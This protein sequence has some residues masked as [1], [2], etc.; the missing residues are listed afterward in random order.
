MGRMN[1]PFG[2]LKAIFRENG[3]LQNEFYMCR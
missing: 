1:C 2:A 3:R